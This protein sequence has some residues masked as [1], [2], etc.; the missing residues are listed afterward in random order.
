MHECEKSTLTQ[1]LSYVELFNFSQLC[2]FHVN[3]ICKN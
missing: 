2:L 1:E 3:V